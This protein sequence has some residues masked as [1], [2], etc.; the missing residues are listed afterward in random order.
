MSLIFDDSDISKKTETN[1][2]SLTVLTCLSSDENEGT[3]SVVVCIIIASYNYHYQNYIFVIFQMGVGGPDI[4]PSPPS[5]SA[6]VKKTKLKN[7]QNLR[8]WHL[9]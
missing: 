2:I 4:L 5:G 1:Y 8:I 7:P 6:H 3:N 9:V